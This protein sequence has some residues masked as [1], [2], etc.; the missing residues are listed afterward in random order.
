MI[1]LNGEFSATL[2]DKARMVLPSA[3]KKELGDLAN[4]PLFIQKNLYKTC[5]DLFPENFWEER[6]EEFTNSLDPFDEDDDSFL[7]YFNTSYMSLE[8]AP[9]GRITIPSAF[10][11][12]S[13]ITKNII[14]IGMG[15]YIRIWDEKEYG[16]NRINK[17]TF[18]TKFKEKRKK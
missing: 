2:D 5:L 16:K 8:M 18:V 7:E 14:V 17:S 1:K 10:K 11:K 13:G 9:N 3:L 6:Y 15:K 12:Y 4:H